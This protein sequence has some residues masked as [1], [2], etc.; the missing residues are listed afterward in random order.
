MGNVILI[1]FMGCGKT[2][3][4]L[5]LSYR[6]RKPV[7]D[8]D[9]EIE[10]EEK[11]SIADIFASDG[12]EYFRGKETECLRKL[13]KSVRN[14]IVSVGGGLPMREVNRELLHE[15]G[16]VFYLRAKAETIYERLQGDT[17][18]PLLQC[19]DPQEKIRVL[20][21]QRDQH[22][23][24]AADVVIQVD[25]KSFEQILNEIEAQ[26]HNRTIGRTN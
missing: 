24:D 8:T 20:M 22:Y 25:G 6:L 26:C 7:T 21:E 4:G 15:L 1:G 3:V 11:R 14:H 12:E 23:R 16:Q 10:R 17:T 13:I 5:R 18:R 19:S 9:K 2:T